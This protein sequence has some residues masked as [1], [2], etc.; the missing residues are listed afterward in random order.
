MQT[1]AANDNL[2]ISK[3]TDSES[4]ST[5]Y[6]TFY[7]NDCYHEFFYLESNRFLENRLE[8]ELSRKGL[9]EFSSI[10]ES[11]RE[12]IQTSSLEESCYELNGRHYSVLSARRKGKLFCI[13]I[14]RKI[15]FPEINNYPTALY[16]PVENKVKFEG[17]SDT[18]TPEDF[19]L[20]L[21]ALQKGKPIN[22]I[23]KI[24]RVK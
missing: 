16:F 3:D 4:G 18:F 5:V 2:V 19:D 11:C 7:K 14:R 22:K 13:S 9:G 23:P 1:L 21:K 24:R 6:A 10:M 17:D 20:F 12:L 8:K 15:P